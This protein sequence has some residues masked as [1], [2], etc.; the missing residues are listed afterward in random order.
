M[1]RREAIG[2]RGRRRL[3]NTAP[4]QAR[5]ALATPS[6]RIRAP[7]ERGGIGRGGREGGMECVQVGGGGGGGG[8]E[9]EGEEEEEEEEEERAS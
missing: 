8:G 9:E 5:G 7:R 1:R 6:P 3:E 2:S 4:G